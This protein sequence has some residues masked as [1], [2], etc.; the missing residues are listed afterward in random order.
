MAFAAKLPLPLS[1]LDAFAAVLTAEN[2]T[3]KR[4]LT[5]PRLQV[6]A[7]SAETIQAGMMTE[8]VYDIN[9]TQTPVEVLSDILRI[10]AKL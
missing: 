8:L 2:H 7:G 5:D 3:L 1:S 6:V 9:A 4:S 10:L